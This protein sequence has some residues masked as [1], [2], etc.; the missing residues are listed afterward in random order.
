MSSLILSH[1]LFAGILIQQKFEED[2]TEANPTFSV[3]GETFRFNS[4]FADSLPFDEVKAVCAHEACHLA[5]LHHTRQ[6]GRDGETWNRA[7]DLAINPRLVRDGFKL[8]A[9]ALIETRFADMSAEDIYRTLAAEKR[10]DPQGNKPQAGKPGQGQ[11]AAGQPQGAPTFGQVKPAAGKSAKEIEAKT[12]GQIEKAVSIAKI[13]GQ[14]SGD[15][16]REIARDMQPRF[17]W[18]EVLHRFFQEITARDYSFAQPNRRFA[19]TGIILPSLR[20]RDIGRIV[21]AIDTSGSVSMEEVSAMVAE[22]QACLEAYCENGITAP[23]T[24]IY[25]DS[26]I[27]GIE[28]LESGDTANPV[29]GG[30][31]C[32]A[33]VFTHLAGDLDGAACLVFLTDGECSESMAELAAL[34]PSYPVLWGLIR[35]NESFAANCPFGEVVKVDVCA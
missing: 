22:M 15:A 16:A 4:A 30:G 21:L 26:S 11:P 1:P 17:D 28:T 12:K 25:C 7:C 8:P 9:G 31:T 27:K 14:L 2:N 29:G 34:A 23:L 32:F 35:D 3:D 6:G 24:V 13:A 33:P 19:H 18:R 5:G 10:Q 20:S